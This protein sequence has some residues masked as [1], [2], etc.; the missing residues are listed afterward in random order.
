MD[1]STRSPT[2][3]SDAPGQAAPDESG[4]APQPSAGDALASGWQALAQTD[5]SGQRP[6]RAEPADREAG[7]YQFIRS[8][9][10][11]G[12]GKVFLARHRATGQLAA[13]K[14]ARD[15]SPVQRDAL[16]REASTLRQLEDSQVSGF[17]RLIAADLDAAVPWYAMEYIDGPSLGELLR[18]VWAAP[19]ASLVPTEAGE[20][21]TAT[22]ASPSRATERSPSSGLDW[23]LRDQLGFVPAGFDPGRPAAGYLEPTLRLFARLSQVVAQLHAQGLVHCDLTPRNVL[24]RAS[25]QPVLIDFGSSIHAF[26]G[27]TMRE[28]AQV[29]GL[30]R[31]TPG[32]MSPEQIQGHALDARCDLYALGCMLFEWITGKPPFQAADPGGLA[33][34]HLSLRAPL[35][36]ERI[37]GVPPVLDELVAGLLAKEPRLRVRQAEDV[38]IVLRGLLGDEIGGAPSSVSPARLHRPRM[39]GREGPLASIAERLSRARDGQGGLIC[40]TGESGVGKTRLANEVAAYAVRHG[41]TVVSSRCY[42][43]RAG[44]VR[45]GG[46]ALGPFFPFVQA[47]NDRCV[48]GGGEKLHDAVAHDLAVLEPYLPRGAAPRPATRG[49]TDD[50]STTRDEAPHQAAPPPLF[51]L[52]S[53]VARER[54]FRSLSRLLRSFGTLANPILLVID[55]LQWADNLTRGFLASSRSNELNAAPALIVATLREEPSGTSEGRMPD[56][57]FGAATLVHLSRLTRAEV[58]AAVKDMLASEL[59]PEGLVDFVFEHSEGNPFFVAEYLLTALNN[60]QLL[61]DR[62]GH[63]V[64]PSLV[65]SSGT[66][67]LQLPASVKDLLQG[68]VRALPDS[69][70]QIAEFASTLGREF[71]LELLDGVIGTGTAADPRL[72]AA[73]NELGRQ[74]FLEEV[75]VNRYRFV[76]D[77]LREA[78]SEGL[79]PERRRELHRQVALRIER[80]RSQAVSEAERDAQLGSHWA[81]AGEPA[82]ALGFLARAAERAARVHDNEEAV[83]LYRLAIQQRLQIPSEDERPSLATIHEAMGD[84]LLQVARHAEAR[85]CFGQALSRVSDD[86][87]IRRA[88]LRRKRGQ[89]YWTTHEYVLAERELDLARSALSGQSSPDA[90]REWIE[91]QQGRFWLLYY[92]RRTGEDTRSLLADMASAVEEHGSPLQRSRFY[93]CAA[94]DL[95]GRGRYRWSDAAV[96][97]ARRALDVLRDSGHPLQRAAAQFELGFALWLGEQSA[98]REAVELLK[99]AAA[100]AEQMGDAT[101][102]SRALTYL[103]LAHRRLDEV[104][105]TRVAAELARDAAESAGLSPY[106]GAANACLGWASW[107]RGYLGLAIR[108][109]SEAL[110]WW[111]QGEHAYPFRWLATLV[112]LDCQLGAGAHGALPPLLDDLAHE[113]QQLLPEPLDAALRAARAEQA[114]FTA[115]WFQAVALLLRAAREQGYL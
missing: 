102:R 36:S 93:Q 54:A 79:S 77:K 19:T 74:R 67:A 35:M 13:V 38:A 5:Y 83:R 1:D 15:T 89:S 110:D 91:V 68:R 20:V 29:E 49:A 85:D 4:E 99:E 105:K 7:E 18:A 70:R 111:R 82:R 63:W 80:H 44:S 45:V 30:L 72:L 104:Q 23:P 107:K 88:R 100:A 87:R 51:E 60:G 41:F 71:D 11:G 2:L 10:Q 47:L 109:S 9:G 57:D 76:H 92:S 40:I 86:Q 69:A 62:V 3:R 113:Q 108:Q 22:T 21:T 8:M 103:A 78:C 43:V 75:G 73:M 64:C 112:L 17:A 106:V 115:A 48:L 28:I 55:D 66:T 81:E 59:L 39:V 114:P 33:R 26:A 16:R 96:E 84:L 14:L 98:C 94:N 27:S 58:R 52:P 53:E 25:G 97:Y 12:T 24:L 101:L 50:E 65:R 31:G 95:L 34:Q 37:P 6:G 90:R 42:D 32:Y 56:P 46:P 61:R